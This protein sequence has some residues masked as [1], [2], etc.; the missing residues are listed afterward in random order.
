MYLA[1]RPSRAPH[2][3]SYFLLARE[4]DD[5][6]CDAAESYLVSSDRRVD[7]S[8]L[9]DEDHRPDADVAV[10]KHIRHLSPTGRD[11]PPEAPVEISQELQPAVSNLK[12]ELDAPLDWSRS[13]PESVSTFFGLF[14]PKRSDRRRKRK[15]S[16]AFL[17]RFKALG[18]N[19]ESSQKDN[20][21]RRSGRP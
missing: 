1:C 10:D 14:G 21:C 9:L 13:R 20:Y 5:R 6:A 16:I 4:G 7:S 15:W 2:P 18:S 19:G 3:S 12:G 17:P 11:G 8:I